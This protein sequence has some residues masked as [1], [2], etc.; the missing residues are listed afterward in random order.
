MPDVLETWLSGVL[1]ARRLP[2]IDAAVPANML[3]RSEMRGSTA[4]AASMHRWSQA[5]QD[6]GSGLSRNPGSRSAAAEWQSRESGIE[7]TASLK[8]ELERVGDLFAIPLPS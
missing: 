5:Y 8:T 3:I 4:F 2:P 1:R 6:A 7:I